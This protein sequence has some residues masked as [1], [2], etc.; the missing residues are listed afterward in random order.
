[1]PIEGVYRTAEKIERE[2]AIG[3]KAVQKYVENAF[4][5]EPIRNRMHEPIEGRH[6]LAAESTKN[7]LPL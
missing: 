6:V 2:V 4:Y 7:M 5:L 3:G 1:V